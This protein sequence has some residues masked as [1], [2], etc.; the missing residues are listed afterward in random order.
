L[1]FNKNNMKN[2]RREFFLQTTEINSQEDANEFSKRVR[3]AFKMSEV[4]NDDLNWLE[5][6]LQ[7]DTDLRNFEFI[8]NPCKFLY[9]KISDL[10]STKVDE[11]VNSFGQLIELH[12]HPLKGDE[13]QLIAVSNELG[14]AWDSG[15]WDSDD[16]KADHREYE[17]SFIDGCYLIGGN[18]EVQSC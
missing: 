3:K 16:L 11:L 10:N 12:E 15:F 2:L 4:T 17:P 7:Q 18:N 8:L 13:A 9:K 1:K 5:Y 14:M 6:Y